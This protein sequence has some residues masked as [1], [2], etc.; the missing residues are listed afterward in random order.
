MN[1]FP[2]AAESHAHSLQ[3]LNYLNAHND[4]MDELSFICDMGCGNGDDLLWWSTVTYFD[5]NDNEVPR[6]YRCVGIDK[7]LRQ[8]PNGKLPKNARLIQEDFESFQLAV[9]ADL[10]W[11]H[12]SFRYAINPL[13][14]LK[15]WNIQINENGML[16]LIV[17]QTVNIVYNKLATR[18][19]PGCYYNHTIASLMYMLAVNGFD[20]SDGQMMKQP[21]DPWL[22]CIAYKSD[23]EPMDP[24]TTSWYH[25]AE[26]GLLPDSAV[27]S[28]KKW[29]YLR[30]EEL[31][32]T[33]LDKQYYLWSKL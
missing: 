3:T 10:I 15:H 21:N 30:Q 28:I 31:V 24:V 11:S 13:S 27:E 32:T 9:K 4:F 18:S 17:P 12:D 33:W 19:F 23:V 5:E 14:T 1:I 7:D 25:L 26:R 20:C 8:V 29:G 6:N 16:V 22:H 2:T